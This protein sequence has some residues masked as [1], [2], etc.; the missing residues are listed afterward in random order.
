[1]QWSKVTKCSASF[2]S[3]IFNQSQQIYL[4]KKI[5]FQRKL[6]KYLTMIL[7]F[8]KNS[9]ERSLLFRYVEY[10]F[11]DQQS[12][13]TH[14]PPTSASANLLYRKLFAHSSKFSTTFSSRLLPFLSLTR[15]FSFSPSYF[16]L[17]HQEQLLCKKFSICINIF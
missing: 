8:K 13:T 17:Y 10:I 3:R 2:S 7:T 1:M 16:L 4:Q 15:P 11:T 5:F 12:M 9:V 6:K 14:R